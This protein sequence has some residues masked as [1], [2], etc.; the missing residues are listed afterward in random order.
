MSR[1]KAQWLIRDARILIS[2]PN[3]TSTSLA[4]AA[5]RSIIASGGYDKHSRRMRMRYRRRRDLVVQALSAADISI[6]GL[7]AG[8]NLTLTL[9]DGAEHEVLQRAGE[10]GIGLQGLAIMRHPHA[11]P[12]VAR[13]D[14]LVV[15]FGTPADHAFGAAL[16]ALR[17]VLSAGGLGG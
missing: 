3:S 16:D 17:A 6:R 7:D 5:L 4:A 11:G 15:G 12:E 2:S 1:Q 10:A 8:L 14:G 9:P 13:S